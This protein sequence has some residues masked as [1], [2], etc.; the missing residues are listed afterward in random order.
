MAVLHQP[1]IWYH[2]VQTNKSSGGY[3][4]FKF[5]FYY[6]Q[7]LKNTGKYN[8]SHTKRN[9]LDT[10]DVFIEF[11]EHVNNNGVVVY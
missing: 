2:N 4:N 11:P 9:S 8:H 1:L 3:A 6:C 7:F 5:L 10:R